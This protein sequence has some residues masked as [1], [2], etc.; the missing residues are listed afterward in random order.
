MILEYE[1][2]KKRYED[3]IK[4]LEKLCSMQVCQK[5]HPDLYKKYQDH[6]EIYKW[7]IYDLE[8]ADLLMSM[9]EQ[10]EKEAAN[11]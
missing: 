7:F 5:G 8:M 6:I 3:N 9:R 4:H 10:I 2:L 1:N 11:E